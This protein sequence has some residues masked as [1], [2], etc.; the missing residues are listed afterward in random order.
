[1]PARPH[2]KLKPSVMSTC[3]HLSNVHIYTGGYSNPGNH[4]DDDI[5]NMQ[6]KGKLMTQVTGMTL[7]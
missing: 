6:K 4:P 2:D 1:M 5:T 7:S 3:T